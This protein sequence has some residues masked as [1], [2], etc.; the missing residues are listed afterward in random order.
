[1]KDDEKS[2]LKWFVDG[3]HGFSELIDHGPAGGTSGDR[4]SSDEIHLI[5]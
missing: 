1:M 2:H 3:F 4:N 5:V